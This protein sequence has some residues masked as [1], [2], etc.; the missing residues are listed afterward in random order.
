LRSTP[1]TG[2][3]DNPNS[4]TGGK[5]SETNRKASTELNEPLEEGHL[6]GNY[7]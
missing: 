5:T 6:R 2:V 1:D 3:T 4:E 7:G